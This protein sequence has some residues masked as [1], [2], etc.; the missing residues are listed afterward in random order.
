MAGRVLRVSRETSLG[1][2]YSS[3]EHNSSSASCREGYWSWN[4]LKSTCGE[5]RDSCSLVSG[6]VFRLKQLAWFWSELAGMEP[7]Y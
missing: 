6:S 1:L 4:E 5:S 7:K 2:G 3:P